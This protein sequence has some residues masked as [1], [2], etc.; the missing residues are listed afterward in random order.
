MTEG[1]SRAGVLGTGAFLPERVLDNKEL[2]DRFGCSEEWILT[3]TG[4]RERRFAEPGTGASDL[5]VVAALRALEAAGLAAKDIDLIICATYTPDMAFPSTACLI[6]DRIGAKPAAAF[7]LQAA[8]SG[9]VYAL[10]TAA[11]F[12]A[13]GGIRHALVVASDVNSTIVDPKDQKVTPLFGDGAGAV[14]VGRVNHGAGLLGFHMGADGGGGPLFFMPAGGSKRP[15]TFETVEAREHYIK[16]DGP[17]L[18]R[19][20]VDAMVQASRHALAQAGLPIEEVDLFIPHQANLR[21]ID[22]GLERLGIPR[23]RT[24]V[25]LDRFANTAAATIPIALDEA[26]K[27]GRISS[28]MNVLMTGFGAGLTWASTVLRWV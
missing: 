20:G 8:C 6:Q 7:D 25:T 28:G 22:A 23:D 9:F 5:G 13:G 10:V 11:Q 18:F 4:I 16:M 1:P 27:D 2:A 3:R 21:I 24:L 17:S 14:V 12:V 15:A 26:V 19:F